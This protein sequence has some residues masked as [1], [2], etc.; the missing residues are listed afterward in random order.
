MTLVNMLV[1]TRY[2]LMFLN[3][4]NDDIVLLLLT[5]VVVTSYLALFN[6][7]NWYLAFHYFKAASEMPFVID[8]DQ[9]KTMENLQARTEKNEKLFKIGL[10]LNVLP[11]AAYGTTLIVLSITGSPYTDSSY[12]NTF[13]SIMKWLI[14]GAQIVSFAIL[15]WS[16]IK[17][18][19]IVKSNTSLAR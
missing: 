7:A 2:L 1:M 4:Q 19:N 9:Y 18:K 6:I 3:K 16:T 13:L 17:I 14:W 5:C 15:F 8:Y 11:I 12:N 10:A